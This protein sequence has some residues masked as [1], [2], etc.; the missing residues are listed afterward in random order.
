MNAAAA[1]EIQLINELNFWCRGVQRFSFT[2]V[3]ADAF[4]MAKHSLSGPLW[5]FMALQWHQVGPGGKY[6]A[7]VVVVV[8][9]I[10]GGGG[11]GGVH[12]GVGGGGGVQSGCIR[13][14]LEGFTIPLGEPSL[15]PPPPTPPPLSLSL[16]PPPP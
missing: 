5:C 8:V 13:E 15:P 4:G 1:N 12:I 7:V 11:G 14:A 9:H 3:S 10:G 16:S 2:A 6:K